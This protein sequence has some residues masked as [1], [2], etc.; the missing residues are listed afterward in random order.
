MRIQNRGIETFLQEFD[1]IINIVFVAVCQN[2]LA[3]GIFFS[4]LVTCSFILSDD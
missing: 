2:V 1:N 3:V 4:N